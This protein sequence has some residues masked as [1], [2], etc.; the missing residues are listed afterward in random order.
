[1]TAPLGQ[2][3]DEIAAKIAA[4]AAGADLTEVGELQ[5]T[6]RRNFNP[7]PPSID[8]Y[9]GDPFRDGT[10]GTAAFNEVGGS[11][12][13]TVRARVNTADNIAGQDFLLRLMDDEDDISIAA[14][15]MDDQTLNGLA[16]S[17]N[18]EGNSGY[19][20]YIEGSDESFLGCEWRVRVLRAL[21]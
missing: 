18:V 8:V 9:P 12:L 21:S 17:V 16:S 20:R 11:L 19:L 1:V 2:L 4:A 14:A 7:T 15:L 10:D 6:S 3:L 5:V 13:L